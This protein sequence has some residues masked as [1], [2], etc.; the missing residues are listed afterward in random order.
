[1]V[2]FAS[3]TIPSLRTAAF[4]SA[5]N[6]VRYPVRS[7]GGISSTQLS[8]VQVKQPETLD[9]IHW[10]VHVLQDL[11][12]VR[13]N[14]GGHPRSASAA[15]GLAQSTARHAAELHTTPA[16]GTACL[17]FPVAWNSGPC[18]IEQSAWRR[19][20]PGLHAWKTQLHRREPPRSRLPFLGFHS[21]KLLPRFLPTPFRM[22]R[23]QN[24]VSRIQNEQPPN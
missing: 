16:A 4:E 1:M 21:S 12:P 17:W 20:L 2:A 7:F 8:N 23:I 19:C 10:I 18:Q 5:K 15:R 6:T 14:P 11:D 9:R 13:L 3:Q 24:S 22:N